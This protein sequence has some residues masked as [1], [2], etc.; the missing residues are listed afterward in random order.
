MSICKAYLF[1][2]CFYIFIVSLSGQLL[3]VVF[4]STAV[5]LA[6]LGVYLYDHSFVQGGK[7][8]WG[9]SRETLCWLRFPQ[10]LLGKR[11]CANC[12][13]HY[14]LSVSVFI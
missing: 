13:H 1:V 8:G 2:I 3:I 5:H 10:S 11:G 4:E 9:G 12:G 7:A 14:P 6:W